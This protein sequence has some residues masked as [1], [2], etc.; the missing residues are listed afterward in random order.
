MGPIALIYFKIPIACRF[1]LFWPFWEFWLS[2]W[3]FGLDSGGLLCQSCTIVPGCCRSAGCV[4]DRSSNNGLGEFWNAV[5]QILAWE[6]VADL[7]DVD[8]RPVLQ[9]EVIVPVVAPTCKVLGSRHQQSR[10]THKSM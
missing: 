6:L 5:F 9:F 3:L 10:L 7:L 4:G 1:L 2:R 8:C